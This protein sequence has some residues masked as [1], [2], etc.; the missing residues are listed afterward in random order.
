L[1]LFRTVKT[2]SEFPFQFSPQICL[3][4]ETSFIYRF[5]LHHTCDSLVRWELLFF[6]LSP[7]ALQKVLQVQLEG[8][9]REGQLEVL[10]DGRVH[11]AEAADLLRLLA[12]QLEVDG[13]GVAGEV[14]GVC[15]VGQ[16]CYIFSC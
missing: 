7:K 16:L 6:A 15:N 2:P 13:R 5:M 10:E 4:R 11:D 14:G 9:S 12:G 1:E 3:K 8:G